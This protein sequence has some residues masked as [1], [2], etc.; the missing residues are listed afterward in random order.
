MDVDRVGSRKKDGLF[1]RKLAMVEET[2]QILLNYLLVSEC[3]AIPGLPPDGA[4]AF[5]T[6]V[7]VEFAIV[8]C[9]A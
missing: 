5:L 4:C 6:N 1:Y 9:I 8:M 3:R 2:A 7:D